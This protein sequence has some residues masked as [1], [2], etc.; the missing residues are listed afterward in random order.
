MELIDF[1]LLMK[2]AQEYWLPLL[3]FS[4][5]LLLIGFFFYATVEVSWHRLKIGIKILVLPV[6]IVFGL[7]DILFDT[8]VG[9]VLF[10]ELPGWPTVSPEMRKQLLHS[11]T[12][13][14]AHSSR[15]N[16]K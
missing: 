16:A 4:S 5:W 1:E 15:R 3:L 7:L 13:C 11:A 8:V 10:C 2:Y 9:T 14:S 12:C 6:V